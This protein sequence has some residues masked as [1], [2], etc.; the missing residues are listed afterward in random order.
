MSGPPAVQQPQFAAQG[1]PSAAPSFVSSSQA[2]ASGGGVG[3]AGGEPELLPGAASLLEQLD[4]RIMIILRDAKHLCG[5]LR[6]FDQFLNL[7]LEDTVERVLLKNEYCD[8]PLGLYIVRGDQIVLLG[9]IDDEKEAN[10]M[11]LAKIEPEELSAKL[12]EQGNSSIV[13]WDFVE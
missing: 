4:K 12:E 7:V 10:E 2:A 3:G 8:V 13:V 9:E 5:K 6:S 1:P 11:S